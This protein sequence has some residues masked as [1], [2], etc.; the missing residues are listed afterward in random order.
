MTTATILISLVS[1]VLC[2]LTWV[3]M[4][5]TVKQSPSQT[6]RK[7]TRAERKAYRAACDTRVRA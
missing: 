6:T 3:Q 5:V 4:P 1:I 2:F 7:F